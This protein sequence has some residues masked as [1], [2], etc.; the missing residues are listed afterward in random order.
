MYSYHG[1]YTLWGDYSAFWLT[2]TGYMSV[3]NFSAYSVTNSGTINATNFSCTSALTNKSHGS[4]TASNFSCN[5]TINYGMVNINTDGLV[6]LGNFKLM[7]GGTINLNGWIIRGDEPLDAK[8]AAYLEKDGGI[9]ICDDEGIKLQGTFKI[10]AAEARRELPHMFSKYHKADSVSGYIPFNWSS[11]NQNRV[12]SVSK[13]TGTQK[14]WNSNPITEKYTIRMAVS[15]LFKAQMLHKL[16]GKEIS[17]KAKLDVFSKAV[18]SREI[19]AKNTATTHEAK[20]EQ[21]LRQY[22]AET[23]IAQTPDEV[24]R[25]FRS[26]LDDTSD[27]KS[28]TQPGMLSWLFSWGGKTEPKEPIDLIRNEITKQ[29]L[30]A[31]LSQVSSALSASDFALC[32]DIKEEICEDLTKVNCRFSQEDISNEIVP[33]IDSAI[34]KIKDNVAL[35]NAYVNELN[36]EMAPKAETD[37]KC[38]NRL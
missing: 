10:D 12:Y 29:M 30:T 26:L 7:K 18:V 32:T 23:L 17:A 22:V 28:S 3:F 36:L 38:Q 31:S 20:T 4:V 1:G 19:E 11:S 8:T 15:D 33:Q 6:N 2:N 21:V 13:R 9:V 27:N 35:A 16:L 34:T 37:S 24:I 25:K 14:F 5:E